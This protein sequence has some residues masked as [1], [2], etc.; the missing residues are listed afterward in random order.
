MKALLAATGF[1]ARVVD[2]P[3]WAQALMSALV[4]AALAWAYYF[5]GSVGP[6]SSLAL[7]ACVLVAVMLV[8]LAA[9]EWGRRI[10]N[11]QIRLGV[12]LLGLRAWL[13][14][15]VGAV[16]VSI[17]IWLAATVAPSD[18]NASTVVKAVVTGW[19]A[20]LSAA[21]TAGLAKRAEGADERVG[22]KVAEIVQSKYKDVFKDANTDGWMAVNS[23]PSLDAS[24]WGRA[25]REKRATRIEAALSAS[26]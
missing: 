24:G 17:G 23:D 10:I 19:G 1:A 5:G 2:L 8:A 7:L 14:L 6:F 18:A 26:V 22:A 9:W 4:G 15:A 16:G 11:P 20:G 25:A 12:R 21:V 3:A 13:E